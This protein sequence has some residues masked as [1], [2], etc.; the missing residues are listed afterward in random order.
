MDKKDATCVYT[1]TYIYTH[2]TTYIYIHTY[3]YIYIHIHTYINTYTRIHI[4]T[5]IHIYTYIRGIL[6]SHIKELNNVIYGNIRGPRDYHTKR[7]KSERERHIPCDISYMWNLKYTTNEHIY[8]T[9]MDIENRLGVAG[10]VAEKGRKIG[11]LGLAGANYYIWEKAMAPDSS[12][13]A[14]KIP[15][16]EE[17][18]RL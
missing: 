1:H 2:T 8:K 7:N 14:W 6:L 11:R 17:P 15:W 9:E 10:E 3:T 13:L 16:T 5:H 12:T 4:Y 18:G